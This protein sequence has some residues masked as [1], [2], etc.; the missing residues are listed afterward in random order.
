MA[1]IRGTEGNDTIYGTPGADRIDTESGD[2]TTYASGG[3]DTVYN[4]N[5]LD[6][7]I[8]PGPSADYVVKIFAEGDGWVSYYGSW[9]VT[10]AG[11]LDT[12]IDVQRAIFSDDMGVAM[13]VSYFWGGD[14]AAGL[15]SQFYHAT[16]GRSP[17]PAGMGYWLAQLDSGASAL[18]VAHG[19]LGSAEYKSLVGNTPTNNQFIE[20]IY[21]NE[22]HRAPDPAGLA[23]WNN[24]LT[25]GASTREQALLDIQNSDEAV[26]LVLIG[27]GDAFAFTSEY[28]SGIAYQPWG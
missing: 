4:Y 27:S 7:I 19:L 28:A 23:F 9:A 16:L 18:D 20:A 8:Y 3:N 26:A 5:D 1:T 2:D 22:F 14:G 12:L 24:V 11:K 25:S 13:D 10:S 15:A 6:K 21:Q 17:D